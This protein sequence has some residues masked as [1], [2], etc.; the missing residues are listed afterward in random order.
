MSVKYSS[1][2]CKTALSPSK[3]PGLKYSL[4]PYL[5]CEHGC[6]YCYSPSTLRD[7][8]IAMNWGKF[9][10]AK[11]NI[12]EVLAKELRKKP[13]GEVGV[14]TICDPYQPLEAK[15]ELT[16]KCIELLSKRSFDVCIQTKSN[17]VLR[18]EDVIKP[19]GF[20][21]GV[22]ITTMDTELAG[23]L[24]PHAS[25]P[26]ARA[27]VLEEFST[28]GVATWI[29]LGPIIPEINDSEENIRRVVE[30]A[31]RTNSRLIYDRLNLRR[32]VFD[33]LTPVIEKKRPGLVK[34]LPSLSRD[35]ENWHHVSSNVES[36]CSELGV[37]CEPAFPS[38]P[39]AL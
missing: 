19:E 28:R 9:V 17:L 24:E 33:R 3:L 29:F 7:E 36:V 5:G 20:E 21:V 35:S 23:E 30:V 10:R 1:I 2:K 16:R 31:K 11:Q 22:T 34:R 8:W 38:W 14:S 13:R 37:R 18:D 6:V 15:L 26:D 4:N 12:A 32:W 25:P 39:S 27:Q